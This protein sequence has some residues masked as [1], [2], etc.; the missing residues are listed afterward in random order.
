MTGMTGMTAAEFG[1]VELVD[2]DAPEFFAPADTDMLDG[3]LGQYRHARAGVEEIAAFMASRLEGGAIDYFLDGNKDENRGRHSMGMSARQ[4]FEQ[5]GAIGALNSAYWSKALALTDVLDIMPQARRT[6][7]HE[8]IRGKKCPDFTEETVRATI[9]TLL[10]QRAQF[11]AERVDG[12][13]RALSGEHVTNA[14][15]GF[16]RRM[17]LAGVMTSYGTTNH[18][19]C[20]VINDLRA[21]VAK[22]MGRGEPRY[23][24]SQRIIQ[25]LTQTYGEWASVDGGA[26]RV[27]LYKKG[28]AH[29]EVHPDMAWRL[30]CILAQLHPRAIPAAFRQKPKKRLKEFDLIKR[31]LPFGVLDALAGMEEAFEQ[32]PAGG[33]NG[34]WDKG[35]RRVP[36]TRVFK[37]AGQSVKEAGE[38][39]KSIGAVEDGGRWV[40]DYEPAAVLREIV[41]SGCIPDQWAH[42]YYPTPER[43]AARLVELADIGPDDR[44][45]EPSAGMGGLA[46]LLPMGRTACIE[47]A[48]LNAKVLEA[49]GHTVRCMDFMQM[50]Q[51]EKFD[52]IV[53]NPPFSEGRW[54]AHLQH[55]AGMLAPGGRL[56]AILPSGAKTRAADLL[57]GLTVTVHGQYDDAFPGASVSVVMVTADKERA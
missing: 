5:S 31:P 29:L 46:D 3:L 28:T 24:S 43:L 2:D 19:V 25:G 54:Q 55:A 56:S 51:G 22:F 23:D 32:L 20:G 34:M 6:E 41:T 38:I 26:M 52:A 40:F 45:L 53:M 47:V 11:V 35:F 37:G 13:F 49:K 33:R 1:A 44:V 27:R 12:I 42:Q 14:P 39:L 4:L 30:N 9:L 16:G 8:Q 10:Q 36:R 18:T 17:I 57:A 21:V 7:W 50:D 48:A 15:E